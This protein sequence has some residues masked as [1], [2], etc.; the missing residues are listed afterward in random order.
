VP[1]AAV[2]EPSVQ[3]RE[4]SAPHGGGGPARGLGGEV[5]KERAVH[6]PALIRDDD[7]AALA[8]H[9]E[10]ARVVVLARGRM[11]RSTSRRTIS[12]TPAENSSPS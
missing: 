8:A 12:A 10:P 5:G 4:P 2:V 7:G 3:R 9:D 6:T 1:L 11:V